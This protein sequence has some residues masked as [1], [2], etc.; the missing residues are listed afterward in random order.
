MD[1]YAPSPYTKAPTPCIRS[2]VVYPVYQGV[3][4]LYALF[5]TL[6]QPVTSMP[7]HVHGLS[8]ENSTYYITTCSLKDKLLLALC[9]D[10]CSHLQ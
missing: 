1:S 6:P 8:T 2:F 3:N 4:P 5:T 9:T 10:L 7:V